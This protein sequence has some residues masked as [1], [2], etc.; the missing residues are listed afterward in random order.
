MAKIMVE[1][2]GTILEVN[3]LDKSFENVHAVD[4]LTF[5]VHAGEIYGLLVIRAF[6]TG[7]GPE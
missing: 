5:N 6:V 3:G 2:N 4:H 1:R 7:S